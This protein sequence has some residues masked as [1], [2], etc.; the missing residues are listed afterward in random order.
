MGTLNLRGEFDVGRCSESWWSSEMEGHSVAIELEYFMYYVFDCP[1][2]QFSVTRFEV[3]DST[4]KKFIADKE[5]RRV[6]S[7]LGLESDIQSGSHKKMRTT[8]M[9]EGIAN[10]MKTNKRNESS[11]I[12]EM[13][14]RSRGTTG[15]EEGIANSMKTNK[16]DESSR[17]GDIQQRPR[18]RYLRHATTTELFM[19][20]TC[21]SRFR[22][23]VVYEPSEYTGTDLMGPISNNCLWTHD[24]AKHL[25]DQEF[26]DL[27]YASNEGQKFRTH[28]AT[29]DPFID[30]W[31][32]RDNLNDEEFSVKYEEEIKVADKLNDF[33]PNKT[34]TCDPVP[35]D[36]D[37]FYHSL[38]RCGP[39]FALRFTC[40]GWWKEYLK[41]EPAGLY[42]IPAC[43]VESRPIEFVCSMMAVDPDQGKYVKKLTDKHWGETA[44]VI[45]AVVLHVPCIIIVEVLM[46][47]LVYHLHWRGPRDR[48]DNLTTLY[49]TTNEIVV[50][51][52][53]MAEMGN[54]YIV[55]ANYGGC[56]Y[57][58]FKGFNDDYDPQVDI[59]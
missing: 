19:T 12:G 24:A 59:S 14:K 21:S 51:K 3:S 30:T 13:Q 7:L 11:H 5:S 45:A 2:A 1:L 43:F 50:V 22:N 37:C 29:I 42:T 15:M 58:S 27:C 46:P 6:Y 41:Y 54:R 17:I 10:S 35:L 25:T 38:R 40:A 49:R 33:F 44:T 16:R 31:E 48:D 57:S 4:L 39:V 36:G 28:N 55:I 8:G 52:A 26:Y 47:N 23:A 32:K 20:Q 53:K 34:I 9:E 18:L 56:H